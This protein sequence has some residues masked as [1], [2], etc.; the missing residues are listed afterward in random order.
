MLLR[1]EMKIHISNQYH[2]LILETIKT[3]NVFDRIRFV[4]SSFRQFKGKY[5]MIE[6]IHIALRL[7]FYLVCSHLFTFLYASHSIINRLIVCA[8]AF[9][10]ANSSY[11]R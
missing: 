9:F 5:Q 1:F 2:R 11:L 7:D 8:V 3:F 6:C 4:E 10:L